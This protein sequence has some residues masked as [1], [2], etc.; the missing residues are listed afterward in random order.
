MMQTDTAQVVQVYD[1]QRAKPL[2]QQP[3][4]AAVE[5]R[6]GLVGGCKSGAS[7]QNDAQERRRVLPTLDLDEALRPGEC[8]GEDYVDEFLGKGLNKYGDGDRNKT[9]ACGIEGGLSR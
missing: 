2:L 9:R 5:E 4:L 3:P 1:R 6:V 8:A 7:G